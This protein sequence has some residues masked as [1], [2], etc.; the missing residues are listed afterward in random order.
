MCYFWKANNYRKFEL[1]ARFSPE[2]V[3]I[4]IT[5]FIELGCTPYT[6]EEIECNPLTRVAGLID[7]GC[8]FHE[9]NFGDDKSCT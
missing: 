4:K 2:D 7:E 6:W 8:P 9:G 1:G 3:P 5:K